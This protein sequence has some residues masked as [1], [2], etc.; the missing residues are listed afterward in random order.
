MPSRRCFCEE[1]MSDRW[2]ECH[3]TVTLER[4]IENPYDYGIFYGCRSLRIVLHFVRDRPASVAGARESAL[5]KVQRCIA[6]AGGVS[7]HPVRLEYRIARQLQTVHRALACP[8]LARRL[9]A[10]TRTWN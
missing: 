10:T 3:D 1:I 7:S 2:V 9:A 4:L 6:A 5:R 8:Q